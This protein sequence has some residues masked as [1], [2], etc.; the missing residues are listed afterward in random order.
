MKKAKLTYG[1]SGFKEIYEIEGSGQRFI[2]S[3]GQAQ[4]L[5]REAV[6]SDFIE[7]LHGCT[8]IS[9]PWLQRLTD[10]Q[11]KLLARAFMDEICQADNNIA[12]DQC[13]NCGLMVFEQIKQPA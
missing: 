6:P 10:D 1:R 7:P 2:T 5:C 9:M 13:T 11:L 4:V 12:N 8:G 3:A